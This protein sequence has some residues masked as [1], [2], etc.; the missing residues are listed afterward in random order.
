M[1]LGVSSYTWTWAVGRKGYEPEKPI[2]SFDLLEKTKNNNIKVLQLADNISLHTMTAIGLKN[3]SDAAQNYGISIEVGTRGIEP[4]KLL[5]YLNIAK[6]LKSIIVRTITHR[7]D[8]EVVSWIKEV[9]PL[10]EEAGIAIALENHD[11]HST[12][13]LA[14][15]VE[16]IG[17]SFLGVCLDTVNSF[18]ALESP[19]DVIKNLAPHTINLHVKDFDIVRAE[20]M[21]GFSIVG[22]PAGEGRLDVVKIVNY[23]KKYRRDFNA[24]LELWT[25]Y[26]GSIRETIIKEDK[27]AKKSI[28]YLKKVFK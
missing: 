9:L 10:Y 1:K 12:A 5:K 2:D 18:A 15:F 24:I 25:P 13:K 11:K 21:H 22:R 3:I 14:I 26:M 16:S 4:E 17:S 20:H 27:W 7:L 8:R 28:K 23:L 19:E 6:K